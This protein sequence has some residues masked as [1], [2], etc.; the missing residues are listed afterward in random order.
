MQMATTEIVDAIPI[1]KWM[2]VAG[3]WKAADDSPQYDGPLGSG[4]E[5]G[6]L[7]SD[8]RLRDG[9]IDVSVCF[10]TSSQVDGTAGVVLG[11]DPTQNGYITVALGPFN[12]AYAISE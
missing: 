12:Y 9:S 11:Y 5:F 6:L 1:E 8:F 4:V 10:K 2:P 7:L 3:N